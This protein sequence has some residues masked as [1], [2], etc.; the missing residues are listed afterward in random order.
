MWE[1]IW[2]ERFIRQYKKL[3]S[4]IRQSVDDAITVLATSDSPSALGTYKSGM[5][6]FSYEL[7]RKHRIIY[8]IQYQ[9]G[10]IELLRVCDHKSAYGKD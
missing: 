8:F 2:S 7:G 4:K 3:D 5:R 10:A 9:A 1:L 6:T